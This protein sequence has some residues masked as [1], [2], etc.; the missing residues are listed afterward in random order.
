MADISV[1]Y[2]NLLK[3]VATS[4]EAQN[5]GFAQGHEYIKI[6][7][8]RQ[9]TTGEGPGE[10]VSFEE[11]TNIFKFIMDTDP[12]LTQRGEAIEY[13]EKIK[14]KYKDKYELK[15]PNKL[16][17]LGFKDRIIASICSAYE[18]FTRY[19][20]Q[21]E[22]QIKEAELLIDKYTRQELAEYIR[23]ELKPKLNGLQ[24]NDQ[25]MEELRTNSET[26]EKLK[27]E[28]DDYVS[29]PNWSNM[30]MDDYNEKHNALLEGVIDLTESANKPLAHIKNLLEVVETIK[31]DQ[32]KIIPS[33]VTLVDTLDLYLNLDLSEADK[34]ELINCKNA[35]NTCLSI[36]G[37]E[38]H[39][40]LKGK[41]QKAVGNFKKFFNEKYDLTKVDSGETFIDIYGNTKLTNS[42]LKKLEEELNG[43]QNDQIM[44]E[45]RTNSDKIKKIQKYLSDY[46]N[47]TEEFTDKEKIKYNKAIEKANILIENSGSRIH[48]KALLGSMVPQKKD[49]N[50]KTVNNFK[51]VIKDI[52]TCL[53]KKGLS[54]A[55]KSELI[56][57]RDK[58][59]AL[60]EPPN[61]G[62]HPDVGLFKIKT[63]ASLDAI[64]DLKKFFETKYDFK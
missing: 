25:K 1:K 12:T 20:L 32:S 3:V 16:D 29:E 13:Y 30:S 4:I 55:D 64:A 44:K 48:I 63:Q 57:C 50:G 61:L 27:T 49:L 59:N 45:L 14:D 56:N 11:I 24:K 9:L 36:H 28:L 41:A 54:T 19:I 15:E 35:V 26:I 58:L 37:G 34:N 10:K 47:L 31:F 33:C 17:K 18:K 51:S 53:L 21:P 42:R 2:L 23:T 39:N 8:N 52:G 40:T 46:T 7:A 43:L 5:K 62:T 38:N 22:N 60:F 6:D